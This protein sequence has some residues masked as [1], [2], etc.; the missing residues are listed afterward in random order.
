MM[1][2]QD[3]HSGEQQTAQERQLRKSR[4]LAWL[5]AGLA[6]DLVLLPIS[7]RLATTGL[8]IDF[9]QVTVAAYARRHSDYHLGATFSEFW[10]RDTPRLACCIRI[11]D[12]HW[13][14]ARNI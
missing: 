13:I 11:G 6:A 4:R 12:W 5:A 1:T 3:P 9:G 2:S 14:V 10:Y 8:K 7:H